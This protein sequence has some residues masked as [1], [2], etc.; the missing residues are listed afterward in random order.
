MLFPYIKIFFRRECP[1][2]SQQSV[3]SL[4]FA[5]DLISFLTAK[6]TGC[7]TLFGAFQRRF[8]SYPLSEHRQLPFITPSGL[9]IGT[10]LKTKWSRSALASAALL[11]RK[12]RTPFIIHE[13]L[14][15][16]GCTLALRKMPF[17]DIAFT[18]LG[19]LSLEVIERYSHL[20]PANVLVSVPR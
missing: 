4:S 7:R 12:S 18:L 14:L 17:L 2:K 6:L 8:R 3:I 5:N 13:A 10:I 1:C 19:S 11:V 20:F 9:R 16:P 15:S